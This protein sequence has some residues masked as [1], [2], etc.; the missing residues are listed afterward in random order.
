MSRM[1]ILHITPYYSPAWAYGGSTRIAYELSTRLAARGHHVSVF[2][3]DALDASRR[4]PAGEHVIDRVTVHRFRNLSNRLAWRRIFVPLGFPGAVSQA[5]PR[6]DVVHLHEVRS[7]LNVWAL[8]SL[9]RH[10]APYIVTPHGGLPSGLGRAA[11][12]RLYDALYGRRLLERACRLH[13]LTD[14]ERQQLL[15]LGLPPGYIT[16]IPNGIDSAAFDASVDV[17]SFKRRYDIPLDNPVVGFLGRLNAIKGLDFLIDAFADVLA[18]HPE[19]ILLIAGPDDGARPALEAQI[20]Q[21]GIGSSVR[22]TGMLSRDADKA[23]A[24]RASWVYVLPSRYENL[25][26]TVLEA[27]LNAVPCILTDRCGL[28]AQLAEAG[29][30]RV[31]PYGD[32]SIL[33]GQILAALRD[34][35]ASRTQAEHGRR[36]V[37]KH[38]NWESVVDRWLEVYHVCVEHATIQG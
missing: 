13:V 9:L 33:A 34:P 19:A 37:I 5:V 8:P 32:A 24:Y 6:F 18:A 14:M 27:L 11:L 7:L 31:V 1:R 26:T 25:P 21:L 16:L 38:F 10:Q 23:A 20:A 12:K 35:A 29:I 4:A 30:A 22:F 2:T 3:T 28:A 36:Y 17:E 15:D